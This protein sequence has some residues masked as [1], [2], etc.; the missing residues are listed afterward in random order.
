MHRCA[1]QG[2]SRYIYRQCEC[3]GGVHYAIL[4]KKKKRGLLLLVKTKECKLDT[5][6]GKC[7]QMWSKKGREKLVDK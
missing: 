5:L 7:V 1:P 3:G 2:T 4:L 6:H